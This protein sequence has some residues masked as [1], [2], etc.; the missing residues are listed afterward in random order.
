VAEPITFTVDVTTDDIVAT[1]LHQL[2]HSPAA[3]R[4]RF[5]AI[6]LV[7]MAT[8]LVTGALTIKRTT[9][10]IQVALFGALAAYILYLQTDFGR[11]GRVR[12]AARM[13]AA[14]GLT[15]PVQI[16]L[17]DDAL[18]LAADGEERRVPWTQL[19][20]KDTSTSHVLLRFTPG[21]TV[22]ALPLRALDDRARQ[23]LDSLRPGVA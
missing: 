19:T 2:E 15:G 17:A 5:L 7:V 9:P 3:R 20:G 11:R 14:R 6:A 18:I 4:G 13:A 16:T 8:V 21:T 10:G 1:Q 12:R 22:V 23:R